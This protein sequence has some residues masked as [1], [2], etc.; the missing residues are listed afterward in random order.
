MKHD[1]NKTHDVQINCVDDH[2]LVGGSYLRSK[3]IHGKT[4]LRIFGSKKIRRREEKAE[5]FTGKLMIS[6][7]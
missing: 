7:A 4:P 2:L 5:G 3:P 1:W 6:G